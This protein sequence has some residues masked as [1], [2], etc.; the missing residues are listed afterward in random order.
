MKQKLLGSIA[1]Y[2]IISALVGCSKVKVCGGLTEKSHS[3]VTPEQRGN[4][5]VGEEPFNVL[6]G[7][8]STKYLNFGKEGSGF[9][10]TPSG[11][12]TQTVQSFKITTANDAQERDPASWQL[13]GTNDTII[14]GDNSAGEAENWTLVDEGAVTLPT[15]RETVGPVVTVTNS[16]SYTSYKMVFPTLKNPA[17]ADSM[18]IADVTFYESPDGT[19]TNVLGIDDPI[20]ATNIVS[21]TVW[22]TVRH[23]QVLN[24]I[25]RGKVDLIFVGDS[26]THGWEKSGQGKKV[27]DRYYAHRNPVNMGFDGDKTQHVLWRFDNGE[28]DGISPK[29]AVLM[30]GTNNSNGQDNTAEEIADGIKAICAKIRH[31]L[32]KTKILML[33]IFP[34]GATPSPQRQKNAMA[35]RLASQIADHEMIYYLNINDHFLEADG[36][37]STDIMPDLLHPNEKG[38]EIWADAIEPTVAKLMGEK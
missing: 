37:L 30:I 33:G 8:A 17:S 14:S 1:V 13:Y 3:A 29:L 34:R 5:P 10:V 25:Q 4:Y 24:R 35:S 11:M 38:Y 16:G 27:W 9:I 20:L 28:I 7:K 6:D 2:I 15:A 32:P 36:T 22:W 26:I 18:Q 23:E 19:G 12:T 21:G 31:K